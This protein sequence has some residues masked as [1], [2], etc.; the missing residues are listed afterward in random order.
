[1]LNQ[2]LARAAE[3]LLGGGEAG[4]EAVVGTDRLSQIVQG[5]VAAAGTGQTIVIP[6]YIGQDRIDEIV[7]KANQR[8]NFRSGGR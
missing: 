7:V 8:T 2:H 4:E 6:V 1:M 3:R 5:A